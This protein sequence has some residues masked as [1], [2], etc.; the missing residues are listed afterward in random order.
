MVMWVVFLM[1][2]RVLSCWEICGKS[3]ALMVLLWTWNVGILFFY[4]EWLL[5]VGEIYCLWTHKTQSWI[6]EFCWYWLDLEFGKLVTFGK[7]WAFVVW[8][9]GNWWR[10]SLELVSHLIIVRIVLLNLWEQPENLRD[11]GR[12][13]GI[14]WALLGWLVRQIRYVILFVYVFESV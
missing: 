9:I 2:L 5:R 14:V 12:L 7:L 8:R 4:L 13:S 10:W 3:S 11:C 6:I 1:V